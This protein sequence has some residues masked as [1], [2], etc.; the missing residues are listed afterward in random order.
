MLWNGVGGRLGVDLCDLE[1]GWGSF[2]CR[3]VR[4][5]RVGFVILEVIFWKFYGGE[6]E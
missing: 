4:F 1:W 6:W 2:R 5:G 3:F